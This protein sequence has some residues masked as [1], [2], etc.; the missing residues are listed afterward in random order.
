MVNAKCNLVKVVPWLLGL[1]SAMAL[2]GC[3]STSAALPMGKDTY[4][5]SATADGMRTAAAAR[6]SAYDVA[7]LKCTSLGR[8]LQFVNETSR[9]TRIGIDTTV[10]IT[11]RCLA[12]TDAGYVRPDVRT[13]P[14]VTIE[15]QRR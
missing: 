11:F 13:A 10:T 12:A 9:D 7:Q 14:S 15:D 2:A 6:E 8:E 4:T 1:A 3:V 5:V